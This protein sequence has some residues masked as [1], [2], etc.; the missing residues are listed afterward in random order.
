MTGINDR[1]DCE[2][3]TQPRLTVVRVGCEM[4]CGQVNTMSLIIAEALMLT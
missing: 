3:Q 4:T 2:K 1:D